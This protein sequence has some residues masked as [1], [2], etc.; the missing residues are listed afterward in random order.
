MKPVVLI[1]RTLTGAGYRYTRFPEH[2]RRTKPDSTDIFETEPV[3]PN[4]PLPA[5]SPVEVEQI[6]RG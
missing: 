5:L 6:R 1:E 3:K 2:R 4:Q